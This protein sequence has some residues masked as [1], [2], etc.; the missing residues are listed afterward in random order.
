MI[1]L[2]H[3]S[4]NS[5]HSR[6]SHV[7]LPADTIW[8][9]PP[10]N[11]SMSWHGVRLL[12]SILGGRPNGALNF[13]EMK[14]LR[15]L[16]PTGRSTD[17][18]AGP[19]LSKELQARLDSH[20]S[21]NW[22][23]QRLLLKPV[24]EDLAQLLMGRNITLAIRDLRHLDWETT[25]VL[26]LVF[27][28]HPETDLDLFVGYTYGNADEYD[29]QGINWSM[30]SDYLVRS[31]LSL[32]SL[33]CVQTLEGSLP[34]INR[35]L[36]DRP[37]DLYGLSISED[38]IFELE[39]GRLVATNSNKRRVV[40]AIRFWFQRFGFASALRLGVSLLAY[41]PR[42]EPEQAA[43][44]FGIIALAAHNRQFRS[45]GNATLA[46]FIEQNLH[47]ALQ[48]EGRPAIRCATLYRLAVTLGRR[49]GELQEARS[50]ADRAVAEARSGNLAPS[51][52]VLQESWGRNIRAYVLT[53]LRM[54]REA[55]EDLELALACL[56]DLDPA[57]AGGASIH[58]ELVATKALLASNLS[59][60]MRSFKNPSLSWLWRKRAQEFE[61]GYPG[62]ARYEA[63][64]WVDLCRTHHRPRV[65]IRHALRGLQDARLELDGM[66][67]FRYQLEAADLSYRAGF[68][69]L[70]R[71]FL[72]RALRL[73]KKFKGADFL[74]VPDLAYA[75]AY[76][77]S[78]HYDRSKEIFLERVP[79]VDSLDQ[80]AEIYGQL[81]VCAS[82]VGEGDDAKQFLQRAAELAQESGERDTLLRT[83]VAAGASF[84]L[85]GRVRDARRAF[86]DASDIAQA[87]EAPVA[88]HDA[89]AVT[90][91]RLETGSGDLCVLEATL[92]DLDEALLDA[93]SWWMLA[94]LLKLM[95][96]TAYEYK[97]GDSS[98]LLLAASQRNDCRALLAAL[99]QSPKS[100]QR[101]HG[102]EFFIP[103]GVKE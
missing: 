5:I 70:T 38:L 82:R 25:A 36:P 74:T 6:S 53:R 43:D 66:W 60:L 69:R 85:L 31:V 46:R 11:V 58:R 37:R 55:I 83:A 89:L 48:F 63:R 42:L 13:G 86:E 3:I 39:G 24:A 75:N 51:E 57:D 45:A 59:G 77:R 95:L 30:R 76:G 68:L 101:L 96:E 34:R 80:R 40:E 18:R 62:V 99:G 61:S 16:L 67:E 44:V 73:R 32:Q 20:L 81:A 64:A 87:I 72:E 41:S 92:E 50:F 47:Q 102:A 10:G 94:R 8:L 27:Q 78:G 4:R 2:F 17:L 79:V 91:G 88:P 49:L 9:D 26:K 35:V 93:D 103:G 56:N 22:A 12:L 98:L 65:G 7:A 84:Q 15:A 52:S 28:T 14:T 29:S 1:T 90:I 100:Y 71:R 19:L 23:I 54:R 97:W 33:E 21:H